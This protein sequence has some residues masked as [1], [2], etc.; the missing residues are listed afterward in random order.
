MAEETNQALGRRGEEAAAVFLQGLGQTIIARNWRCRMGE[1]DLITREG[2]TL[3]FC[4]VKTRQSLRA[5]HP[6]EAVTLQKQTRYS[7]LADI[8]LSRHD[9]G[10]RSLRFDVVSICVTGPHRAEISLFRSA[11]SYVEVR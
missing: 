11:F 6:V 7:R 1:I 5:G 8:W 4:E 10:D 2:D 3:V 9:Q